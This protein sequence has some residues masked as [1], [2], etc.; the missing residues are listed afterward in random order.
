MAIMDDASDNQVT[1][2][3]VLRFEKKGYYEY[4]HTFKPSV[5]GIRT[6]LMFIDETSGNSNIKYFI[7][8]VSVTEGDSPKDWCPHFA[9]VLEGNTI[10]DRTGVKV[11]NGGFE[12][13]NKSQNRTLFVDNGGLVGSDVGFAAY[14]GANNSSIHYATRGVW[15]SS[16]TLP[17]FIH[18]N[19]RFETLKKDGTSW[20]KLYT[21][22][23]RLSHTATHAN[24]SKYCRLGN[25][26]DGA[27]ELELYD[28]H[29][30]R[31]LNMSA[32]RVWFTDLAVSGSK[33]RVVETTNHGVVA[34]NAYE[35]TTPYFGDIGEGK[36]VKGECIIFIDPVLVETINTDMSYHVF[37]QKYGIG[38]LYV[39]ERNPNY[40]AVKGEEGLSFAWELKAKQKGYEYERLKQF[41]KR[42]EP[43][44]WVLSDIDNNLKNYDTIYEIDEELKKDLLSD[45]F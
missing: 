40:F 25:N 4:T 39:S 14:G 23:L 7:P 3:P 41:T 33:N 36:I 18:T 9:E 38:E 11:Y 5:S 17:L 31:R 30:G 35:T 45:L 8:W 13:F 34:L 19:D 29:R 15:Q 22:E 27:E 6:K 24:G 16:N 28:F 32:N 20:C 21:G 1:I 26:Y 2:G 12:V 42:D 44:S 43:I 10:I 37:L